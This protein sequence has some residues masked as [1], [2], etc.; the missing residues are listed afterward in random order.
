MFSRANIEIVGTISRDPEPKGMTLK[1]SVAVNRNKK[2]QTGWEK[3]TDWYSVVVVGE[4]AVKRVSD[5]CLQKGEQV[6]V[7]GKLEIGPCWT[8]KP[9]VAHPSI[10]V[11]CLGDI[12]RTQFEKKN[13]E[14]PN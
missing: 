11:I 5:M 1:I 9:G 2:T 12:E 13:N 14:L 4:N 10:D 6:F 7:S 8:D 3:V